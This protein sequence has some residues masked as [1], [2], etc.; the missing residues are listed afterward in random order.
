[1]AGRRATPEGRAKNIADSAKWQ[2]ENYVHTGGAGLQPD[3]MVVLY[4]NQCLAFWAG[5][6][7][8]G[9]KKRAHGYGAEWENVWISKPMRKDQARE[10]ENQILATLPGSYLTQDMMNG[11]KGHTET[12][13]LNELP[14]ILELINHFS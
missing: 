3:A 2:K 14:R 13:D 4:I 8:H 11:H 9:T 5:K 12:F 6:I 10:I 7:G 1:M